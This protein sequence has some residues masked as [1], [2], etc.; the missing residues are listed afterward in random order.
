[1]VRGDRH[2]ITEAPTAPPPFGMA[3]YHASNHRALEPIERISEVL[4]GL[5]MV[6]TFTCSFSVVEAGRPE[7]RSLLIGALGCN[8]AWGII[9]AIMYLMSCLADRARSIGAL[10][11]VRTTASPDK[12]Q[13]H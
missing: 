4:F 2:M 5:I 13:R 7:V 3:S 12:A 1:S 10:R 8:F 11:A 6:L 9:D